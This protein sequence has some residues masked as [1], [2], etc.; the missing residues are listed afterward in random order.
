MTA[1]PKAQEIRVK[2]SFII[3]CVTT[4]DMHQSLLVDDFSGCG[5]LLTSTTKGGR[6]KYT[7]TLSCDSI[8]KAKSIVNELLRLIRMMQETYTLLE[9]FAVRRKE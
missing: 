9:E 4:E 7:F 8:Y 5:V 3:E 1:A 2:I 6:L